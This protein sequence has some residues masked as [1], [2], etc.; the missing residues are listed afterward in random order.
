MP[1]QPT[2]ATVAE[3]FRLGIQFGVVKPELAITWAEAAIACNADCP[4]EMIDVAWS[5]G[6]LSTM[7]ALQTIPG[8]RNKALA[9]H[10]L[11]GTLR[12]TLSPNANE[13]SLPIQRAKCIAQ[14]AEFGDE[15]FAQFDQLEDIFELAQRRIYGSVEQCRDDLLDALADYPAPAPSMF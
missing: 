5:K 8:D 13:I 11:L 3:Y 4:L 15:V 14:A 1:A 6:L 7:D 9:G 12:H 2:L 10:W